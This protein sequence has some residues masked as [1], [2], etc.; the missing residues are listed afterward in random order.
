MQNPE[1]TNGNGH[2]GWQP[3]TSTLGGAAIGLAAAQVVVAVCD[4]YFQRPLGPEL[5]SAITTLCVAIAGY[6]F[7]DGGRR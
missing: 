2:S 6:F 4:Q 5:A 7:K 3:T 1:P